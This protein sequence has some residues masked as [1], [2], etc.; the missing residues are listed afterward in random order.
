MRCGGDGFGADGPE[1][2][3]PDGSGEG[4]PLVGEVE[5][6]EVFAGAALAGLAVFEG[7]ERGV[8]DEEG[9]VG[10]AQHGVEVGGVLDEF[11]FD[12]PEAGEEDAGVGGRGAGGGVEG[13]ATDAVDAV[14]M[15][16]DEK[17]GADAVARGNGAAGD[18]G[19]RSG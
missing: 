10:G 14:G 2:G 19:K 15:A 6:E 5:V 9:G 11:R 3:D 1:G 16:H 8:A 4:V 13:D 17:D 18:D 12:L 7:E